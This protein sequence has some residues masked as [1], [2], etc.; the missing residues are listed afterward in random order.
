MWTL[1][2]LT[3]FFICY[4]VFIYSVS[5]TYLVYI[6]CFY[7]NLLLFA[8]VCV[9]MYLC[10]NASYNHLST[11]LITYSFSLMCS[12]WLP[13][14]FWS[15][16]KIWVTKGVQCPWKVTT[17]FSVSVLL[18]VIIFRLITGSISLCLLLQGVLHRLA[19]T[20]G[21][22]DCRDWCRFYS[23]CPGKDSGKKWFCSAICML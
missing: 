12:G 7:V 15:L 20:L 13:Y 14:C 18:I 23:I 10:M 17:T 4:H 8:H 11:L 22:E 1:I 6:F 16:A 19:Y 2:F 21:R 5:N 3:F 9:G